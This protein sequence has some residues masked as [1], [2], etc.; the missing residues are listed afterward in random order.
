MSSTITLT[1]GNCAENHVGMQMIGDKS[2]MCSLSHN[3]LVRTQ[4][5]FELQGYTCEMVDLSIPDIPAHVLVIRGGVRALLA[6]G[7]ADELFAEQ[8]SLNHDKK[9]MM[10]GA[11]VN[12]IARWNLCFG[13][14]SQE[15]IYEDGKGRVI[16]FDAVP[17]TKS[18]RTLIPRLFGDSLTNLQ[19]EGNY[20]YDVNKCGIGYH[21]DSERSVV[22]AVRLGASMPLCF[23]WYHKF[24]P[25]SQKVPIMLNHGDVY[26][27]SEKA[28]GSDWKKSSIYTLRHAAGCSKYI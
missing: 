28:V 5:R 7:T 17:L 20:Y 9:A 23:Q 11:V 19:G 12:K 14:F 22:I 27:M 6:G 25:I 16:H 18:I 2:R 10:K 13:D 1:F 26:A 15:P 24:N 4:A 3:D 21:G 8:G